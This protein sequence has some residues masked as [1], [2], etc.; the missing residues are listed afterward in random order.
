MALLLCLT[1]VYLPS[2]TLRCNRTIAVKSCCCPAAPKEA[3]EENVGVRQTT[4]QEHIVFQVETLCKQ[5]EYV[6]ITTTIPVSFHSHL[7]F[8]LNISSISIHQKIFQK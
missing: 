5:S 6:V 3:I 4:R 7:T 2:Q 1:Y 8:A